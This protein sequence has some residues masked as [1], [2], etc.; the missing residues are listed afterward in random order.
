MTAQ[1]DQN[2][3]DAIANQETVNGNKLYIYS[4]VAQNMANQRNDENDRKKLVVM[5]NESAPL[6]KGV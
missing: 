2:Y 1:S 6:S 4:Q 5:L 3:N